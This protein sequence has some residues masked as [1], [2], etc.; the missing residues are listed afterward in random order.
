MLCG[1]TGPSYWNDETA[2]ISATD[3][4]LP[5]LVRMLGHVDAVHGLYYLLMWL[6]ARV[7]GTSE[8][9]FRLPSA[10]A[11]ALVAVGISNI[12]WRLRCW[13]AGLCAGV[14]FPC[15]PVVTTWGQN[16]RPYAMEMAAAALASYLLL[17]VLAQPDRRRLLMYGASLSLLGYLNL[18]GLLIIPAHAITIAV[19]ESGNKRR[20]IRGWLVAAMLGGAAVL[21]VMALG[22]H[23]RG[24]IAWIGAP[25]MLAVQSLVQV[26][27]GGMPSV[28][29]I[30]ALA[31]L[32]AARSGQTGNRPPDNLLTWL[33]LPWLLV[34]PTILLIA[35]QWF[36]AYG[37]SYVLYCTPPMAMLAGA[38]LAVLW[39]PW[40]LVVLGVIVLVVLPGQIQARGPAS[41]GDDIRAVAR[42][43]QRHARDGQAVLYG[44]GISWAVPDWPLAYSYGF[45][46]LRDIGERESAAAANDLFGR[47]V[48][49]SV[50]TRRLATVRE[51]W[52]VDMS[53]VAPV[54]RIMA[55]P[56]F[57]PAGTWRFPGG[58]V[59]LYQ[60]QPGVKAA[61]R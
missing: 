59:R 27:G 55:S 35:S 41:H 21:P 5:G 3:R 45:T 13:Q 18:F 54:L 4:P 22:W 50:L 48:S 52:V 53:R 17:N 7:A 38:G 61:R 29:I 23:Q 37:L 6:V 57:R 44:G 39:Q 24:Q 30:A 25:N 40:R 43:L 32:G 14:L 8:F 34:P 2:T 36:H 42:F 12:V 60:K 58:V 15:I 20:L 51:V 26:L 46:G 28:V 31:G 11:M 1:I 56:M 9:A 16:A 47:T 33:C 10:L 49:P 19:A